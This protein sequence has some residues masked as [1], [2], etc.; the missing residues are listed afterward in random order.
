MRNITEKEK[1]IICLLCYTDQQIAEKLNVKRT[2]IKTRLLILYNK[3]TVF[4]RT[5]LL[6]VALKQGIINFS[7]VES[8]VN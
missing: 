6:Y 1:Q 8:V 5:E 4:N 3:L 7:D 2:T